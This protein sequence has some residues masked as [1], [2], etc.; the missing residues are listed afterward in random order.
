MKNSTAAYSE[1]IYALQRRAA[2]FTRLEN[3]Q[4]I[5]A[6][7]DPLNATSELVLVSS[8]LTSHNIQDGT[9]SSF[10]RGWNNGDEQARW[11]GAS[12][13]ICSILYPHSVWP[14]TCAKERITPYAEHWVVH[15][16]TIQYCLVGKSTDNGNRCGLHFSKK[17]F[18]VIA[19]CLLIEV[20]LICCVA[21]LS[22]SPT[23]MTLGDA[24]AEFLRDPDPMTQ[25]TTGVGQSL[26][27]G[28]FVRLQM[29]EWRPVR[30]RWLKALGPKMWITTITL[31]LTA[32]MLGLL[33]FFMSLKSSRYRGMKTNLP[34]IWSQG[35][36]RTN[37]FALV[38]GFV[39][40]ETKHTEDFVSHILFVNV[41][42]VIISGLYLLC[43]SSLTRQVVA[44]QWTHFMT[45]SDGT[46]DRKPLRV[47]SHVGLQ[48]T[49]Y[50]LSLP[51]TYASPLML[52]FAVLHT[53]I[54]RSC[55][56]VRTMAYGPG[57]AKE[58][59]R[60]MGSDTSRVGYSSMGILLATMTGTIIFLSLVA[61][62]FR[63]FP[64]V[65]EHLP[66]LAN[67]TAFIS[68]ACQRPDG[69]KDAHLFAVTFMAVDPEPDNVS[70][71]QSTVKRIVLSTDRYSDVPTVGGQYVQPNAD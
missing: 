62:S 28:H 70:G 25:M 30:L 54:A 53:L 44:D 24:Q 59:Q 18:I 67:K 45:V 41:F 52:A 40:D 20:W 65:P 1:P 39:L 29:A 50:M 43:N 31:S 8:T 35:I 60:M 27:N 5:D 10:L 23:L 12:N 36:G 57:P 32:I 48:R 17:V 38:G 2:N 61:N 47:S 55:F 68:A 16:Y 33:A 4:C 15:D 42:Q 9:E 3:L 49:S 71:T 26:E 22:R 19:I 11:D 37:S 46:P 6:Y 63:S 56:L 14:E 69:D 64:A 58:S 66:R 7:I 13:W 21:I 34:D 51:W